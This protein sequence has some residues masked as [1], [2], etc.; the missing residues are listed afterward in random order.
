MVVLYVTIRFGRKLLLGFMVVSY[1]FTK[2]SLYTYQN[3]CQLQRTLLKRN[4]W[5]TFFCVCLYTG[6]WEAT[7]DAHSIKLD[8]HF[9]N[10][11]CHLLNR[12]HF[13]WSHST[14]DGLVVS[15][16]LYTKMLGYHM[17]SRNGENFH[18]HNITFVTTASTFIILNAGL[19]AAA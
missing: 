13:L 11:L 5:L 17:I 19:H 18:C 16:L 10:T 8:T 1:Q 14:I 2:A 7:Q 4:T 9:K 3:N 12:C 15:L 6:Y